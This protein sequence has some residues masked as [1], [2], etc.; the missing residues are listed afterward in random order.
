MKLNEKFKKGDFKNKLK[1]INTVIMIGAGCIIGYKMGK[2]DGIRGCDLLL[3]NF[4]NNHE[5]I[6][7]T[8]LVEWKEFYKLK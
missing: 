2:S 4:L 3:G 7:E 5:D 6:K 8:F 1:K